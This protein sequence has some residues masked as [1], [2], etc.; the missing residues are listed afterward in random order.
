M[1]FNGS[2]WEESQPNA[3]GIAQEL[4]AR[5]LGEAENEIERCMK[6][7]SENGV[8]AMQTSSAMCRKS[9]GLPPSARSISYCL[10]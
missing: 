10:R 1:V 5:Q 7:M 8:W 4:T 3:Q 2:F 6:E 9:W